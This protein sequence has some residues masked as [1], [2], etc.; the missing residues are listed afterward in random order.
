MQLYE[1][2]KAVCT[3]LNLSQTTLAQE[4]GLSQSRFNQ[5]LNSKSQRNLWDYL[6]KILENYPQ[7]S[8]D[9]LYFGE[10]EPLQKTLTRPVAEI[11]HENCIL[12]K[13]LEEER[14]INKKLVNRLLLEGS[15]QAGLEG[16]Q[17]GEAA[18]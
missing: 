5:Y 18:K 4:L 16:K 8:R 12:K 11:E 17:T 14:I 13:E 3:V 10:G 6:P 1:R 2:I 9:W 7:I 15:P